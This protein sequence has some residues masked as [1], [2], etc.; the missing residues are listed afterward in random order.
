MDKKAILI[1]RAKIY[2]ANSFTEKGRFV[3]QNFT[4]AGGVILAR[5]LEHISAEIFVQEYPDLMFLSRGITVN[6]EGGHA[7]AIRKLKMQV[8]GGFKKAGSNTNTTGK[9]V[10]AGESDVITTFGIEAESDWSEQE[11]QEADLEGINLPQRYF[12]GHFEKYNQDIDALGYLGN[13]NEAGS[14]VTPGLLTYTGFDT[15]N[16]ADTADN[17]TGQELYDEIAGLIKRQRNNVFNTGTYRCDTVD[18]PV[19]VYLT[20]DTKILNSNG[21]AMTVN[22]ALRANHPDIDFGMTPKADD[23]GGVSVTVAYSKNRRSM[24]FRVPVPLRISSVYQN[25]WKS[26]VESYAKLAGLDIIEDGAAAYLKGL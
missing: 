3:A 17:L 10:M 16:A 2:D 25:G 9:I 18:M 13:Y 21:S 24:Q 22:A 11:L 8:K 5:N 20:A 6:N 1:N 14:L 15:D 4:D 12:D 26:Y 7:S 23:V 19:G